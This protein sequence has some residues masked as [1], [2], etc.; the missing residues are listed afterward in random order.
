[1]LL[2]VCRKGLFLSCSSIIT[3]HSQSAKRSSIK[4]SND[5]WGAT[6]N[7]IQCFSR[8]PLFASCSKAPLERYN[9]AMPT[10]YD[11]IND[12]LM[13]GLGAML[14]D[15]RRADFCVGYFNLRGWAKLRPHIDALSGEN[16]QYCRLLV[17]MTS[18]PDNA[19]KHLYGSG[20]SRMTQSEVA[21]LR[22]R[23]SVSFARQ[24]TYGT[25]T[26]SDQDTLRL[27]AG[28]LRGGR[29]KVKLYTRHPLHAKLYLVH[30]A[31]RIASLTGFVGSSNLTLSGLAQNGEL[32]VDVVEQDAAQKLADW[33]EQRWDDAW[34]IDISDELAEIIEASWANGPVQPYYI[35]IKTAW[36]LSRQAISESERFRLPPDLAKDLLEHQ[37]RAVS[38]AAQRLNHQRGVIVGDVVGLG[39][40]LVATAVAKVFQE[41]HGHNVLVICPPALLQNWKQHLHK[42]L[43]AGNTLSLGKV[44]DLKD[45]H[46]YRLVILDE[47][48]NLRNRKS[49]RHQQVRDYIRHNDCRVIMLTATPYNKAYQDIASQL[50]LFLD[51]GEDLGIVP[52]E[53]IDSSGGA[54]AFRAKHP[55]ILTSSL[56]AFELSEQVDDWR[57]LMRLFMVRR[58]RAH[59]KQHYAEYDPAKCRYYLTFADGNRFYFPQREPRRLDFK[60]A[61]DDQYARLYSD[62]VVE[63]IA[64]LKLPRYGLK[65]YLIATAEQTASGDDIKIIKH[66]SRAGRRLRGFARTGLFKRLESGGDAFLLSLRRHILRNA[67]LVAAIT[68]GEALPIGQV[69]PAIMDDQEEEDDES[70]WSDGDGNTAPTEWE[71]C[72]IAGERLLATL[73]ED[74]Q[75]HFDWISSRYF[76]PSLEVDL[77][78]DSEVLLRISAR[79]EHWD[80]SQDRKLDALRT[81]CVTTHGNEKILIFSQYKDTVDYL[82]RHLRED[83]NALGVVHSDTQCLQSTIQRF[84]PRA[85]AAAIPAADELRVLLTTD[86]LSEGVNLQDAHIVVN[87]DLPWAI[88]RLTQRVGRVDRIGQTAA[89]IYCYS[90]MPA[91]GIER[92]INLRHR[93]RQRMTEN[94]ELIGSDERFFEGE[95]EATFRRFYAGDVPL[96][97]EEEGDDETDLIS[98]AYDIWQQAIKEDPGLSAI[99]KK[100]QDVVYSAKTSKKTKGVVAYIKDNLNR[101]FLALIDR[102]GEIISRSQHKILE[103]LRCEATEE[104]MQAAEDHHALVEKAVDYCRQ[105]DSTL[106]GQLGSE[107]STRHRV[108]KRLSDYQRK[109]DSMLI[110]D[111]DSDDLKHAIEHIYHWP[112]KQTASNKL[113]R[114]I[115]FKIKDRDLAAMLLNF[116]R[117]GDLC[118]VPKNTDEKPEPQIICSSGLV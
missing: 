17:G 7:P 22:R 109:Q 62:Q 98:R 28:Q 92:V 63:W 4:R 44:D 112:L 41:D 118:E 12:K 87:Y 57:E 25:P 49:F 60:L 115:K 27:L 81:L 108:Y 18:D 105:A 113:Q 36:H 66:L 83:I 82:H 61:D 116:W 64:N 102:E 20:I 73:N 24:L 40:T 14:E 111:E 103:L 51:G 53:M 21:Q 70:Q 77:R 30:R 114:E 52:Q 39:K 15:A 69:L 94:N 48:H 37:Q 1:M 6:P 8:P 72:L 23:M 2:E 9:A 31:D 97:A 47:S 58:T 65:H 46:R 56:A 96:E 55:R 80:H 75:R 90:A 16:G 32:N 10:I 33:F 5:L 42:Y 68:K 89:T 93:L 13:A 95:N 54:V 50:L 19:V 110:K 76:D 104:T 85:N 88:I 100:L 99:I 67:M 11:N 35:Y 29:L 79:V 101:H 43:I 86:K 34:S 38:L 84:S 71:Q 106:G 26:N 117:A 78:S 3:Q 74:H 59:I 107:N 91:E 45:M